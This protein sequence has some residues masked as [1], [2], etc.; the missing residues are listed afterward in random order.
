MDDGSISSGG[1]AGVGVDG[2]GAA[3]APASA[4][5]E[6]FEKEVRP[7]L[8]DRCLKCHGGEKTRGGLK[9][10]LA[11]GD[12][13]GRRQRPGRHARQARRQPARA[14]SCSATTRR[15]MPKGGDKLSG[16]RNRGPDALGGRSAC[17]TP[18]RRRIAGGFHITDEQRR[19]WAFQPVKVGAAAGSQGQG[20]GPLRPRS[21]HPR[22]A[23]G[24]GP[25]TG[26]ARRQ[27]DADSPGDVRPDRPAADAGRDRRL[28]QGRRRRT[29]SPR[30]WTGCWRRRPTASAGAGTGSTW[31]ATPIRSTPAWH[32]GNEMDCGDAWRYRDWV[33]DAFN[34]TCPTT[35]SSAT[36]WPAILCP[37][38]TTDSI[39]IGIIAT[40]FLAIGNWGGGDADKDKLLTDIADDQV[41]V[42][43]PDVPR[44]DGG[45]RPLPRPQ[46]RPDLAGRLL[47]AGRHL[48]QHAHPA[49]T[50]GRRPTGRRCCASR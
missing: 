23:G 10:D 3:D 17:P 38:R 5:D 28:S 45:L 43:E 48:L 16:P 25:E 18:P 8:V 7:L 1:A 36:S 9:L 15:R 4:G 30:W 34:R 49:R 35:S 22:R 20:L 19:F 42:D 27:A 37:A 41:D 24:E 50:L 40:G 11:R 21:L 14:S 31:P 44:P 46:V 29:P 12:P 2:V 6:F 13:P 39:R 47:R 32:P 33:I 26:E